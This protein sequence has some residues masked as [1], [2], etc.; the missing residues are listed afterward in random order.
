MSDEWEGLTRGCARAKSQVYSY[1]PPED[2]DSESSSAEP[3]S[4]VLQSTRTNRL[5]MRRYAVMQKARDADVFGLLVGN[6]N[7]GQAP[8]PL[9]S[10]PSSWP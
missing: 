6:V 2:A 1:S 8:F 9:S 4:P 10:Y 7:L 5:L 3:P